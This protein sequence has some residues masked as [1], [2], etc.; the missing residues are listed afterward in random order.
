MGVG[1]ELHGYRDLNVTVPSHG[2]GGQ[3]GGECSSQV[4]ILPELLIFPITQ[5]D[6]ELW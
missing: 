3:Q 1:E 4:H 2:Q 6:T 5:A